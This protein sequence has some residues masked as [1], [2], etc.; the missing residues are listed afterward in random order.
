MK[1]QAAV[2]IEAGKPLELEVLAGAS[3]GSF[4]IGLNSVDIAGGGGLEIPV[5]QVRVGTLY[6]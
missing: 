5:D 6:V 2:A 4:T 1:T 3:A